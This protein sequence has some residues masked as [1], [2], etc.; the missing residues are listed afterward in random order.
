MA[1]IPRWLQKSYDKNRDGKI[2]ADAVDSGGGG[3]LDDYLTKEEAKATYM[4]VGTAYT[5]GEADGKYLTASDK[6]ELQNQIN[7]LETRIGELETP[8]G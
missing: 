8:Q 7:A 1:R 4:Q 6:T 3:N 5:K 2:D